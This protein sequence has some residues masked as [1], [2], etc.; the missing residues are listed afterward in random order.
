MSNEFSSPWNFQI[1]KEHKPNQD[2]IQFAQDLWLGKEMIMVNIVTY[3][4]GVFR[5]IFLIV[6]SLFLQSWHFYICFA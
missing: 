1:S 5:Q 4:R 3:G 2:V 6:K